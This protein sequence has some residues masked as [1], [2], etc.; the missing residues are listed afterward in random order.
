MKTPSQ[1]T[2]KEQQELAA[3]ER[4]KFSLHPQWLLL[5]KVPETTAVPRVNILRD[6]DTTEGKCSK[7]STPI[8]IPK[9]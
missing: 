7:T 4:D 5:T 8:Q 2:R 3:R 6:D 9:L 1:L